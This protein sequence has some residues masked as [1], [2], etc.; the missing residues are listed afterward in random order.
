MKE[1]KAVIQPSRLSKI[2]SALRNIK[3]F[4]GSSVNNM[5]HCG[6]HLQKPSAGVREKLTD[7][8]PKVYL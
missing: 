6:P 3:G 7:Y 2:R 1:I 8:S 5:Q 4:P